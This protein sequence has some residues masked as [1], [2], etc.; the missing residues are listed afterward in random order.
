MRLDWNDYFMIMAKIAS[1]LIRVKTSV[2][3]EN[4]EDLRRRP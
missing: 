1:I 3:G 2:I 4:K